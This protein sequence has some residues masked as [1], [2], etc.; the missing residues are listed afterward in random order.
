MNPKTL[1]LQ[2]RKGAEN[3]VFI[4]SFL[5]FTFDGVDTDFFVILFEGGKILTSFGEFTFFH[6]FTDIPVDESTFGVHEIELVVK[7]GPCFGNGGGVGQHAYGTLDLGKIT[8]WND[9]WWLVIDTDLET[10]W[11]PVN[12]LDGTFGLD[13]GNGGVDILGDNI[14]T[15]QHTTGH[16]FTV[17]WITF[18][19]LVGWLE[20]SVGDLGNGELLVVGLLGRDD[21]SVGDQWEM[22]TWV[23][24]QVSLELSKIDVEGTIES[25]G[26]GDGRHNLTNQTIQIGVGWSFDIQVTSADIVDGLVVNHEGTVRVLQGGVGGEDGVVWFDNSGGNL[27]SWVDSKLQLG[28]LTVVNGQTFHQKGSKT[29]TGTTTEGVED[30]ETLKTGTLISQFSDSVE[31]KVDNFLTNGVVTSGV[32]IGGIFFTGDQLFWMEELT[33]STSSDFINDSWFQINENGTWDMFAS[34][35]FGEEGVE[36]VITTTDGFIGWHLTVRLDTVLQAVEFPTGITD[37]DTSLANMN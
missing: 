15:V 6:T 21:W 24:D 9:C 27:W 1:K 13:G 34:T 23:W 3:L 37:L 33:V 16:V 36:G 14:T 18:D 4:F 28:F 11:A 10:S 32:V 17:T 12:E 29:G 2:K 20:A 22:D 30:Q 19:H 25:E 5:G 26:C 8:T 31:D 35:S 7:S